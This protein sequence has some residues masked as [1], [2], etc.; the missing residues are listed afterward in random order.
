MRLHRTAFI[1]RVIRKRRFK[2]HGG[3]LMS[4]LRSQ[5]TKQ[6]V[7]S[8]PRSD[9]HAEGLRHVKRLEKRTIKV[10]SMGDVEGN[11]QNYIIQKNEIVD[12]RSLNELISQQV[13]GS[14]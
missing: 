7:M 1:T 10:H 9:V 14:D 2:E 12:M 3:S 5:E 11:R 8:S 4:L 6:E 13:R